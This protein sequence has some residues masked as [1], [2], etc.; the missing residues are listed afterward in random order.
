M[1]YQLKDGRWRAER[2][3]KG[4]RKTRTCATKREALDFEAGVPQKL[5]IE[6]VTQGA[7]VLEWLNAYLDY[8][9]SRFAK[10]VY[11]RKRRAAKIMLQ[12]VSQDTD[13][14]Q[15]KPKHALSIVR[16]AA[17]TWCNGTGNM[18]RSELGAAWAWGIKYEGLPRENPFMMIEKL[19][20][21]RQPRHVP[22]QEDF[23][24]VLRV[25]TP[26]DR[27]FLL[28]CLHT[29][30]RKGELFRLHWSE[31]DF[32]RE[33]VLLGT[34]KRKGGGM[35]YDPIPMTNTLR[36]VLMEKYAERKS[37]DEGLVFTHVDGS[38]YT[39]RQRLTERLCKRAGVQHFS[40]HG[41]RHLTASILAR[42]GVP[43]QQIQRILRHRR[44][45]TTEGYIAQIAPLDN[46]LEQVLGRGAEEEKTLLMLQHQKRP[47]EEVPHGVPHIETTTVKLQ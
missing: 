30:A 6:E 4:K 7:T 43:M 18:L 45:A 9:N 33:Y 24:A 16:Y 46:V 20:V 32:E 10:I 13:C 37:A 42:E 22:S 12:L 38:A 21:D 3:V 19:S 35:E 40:L 44:L 41:I 11:T 17:E 29:A 39:I 14:K 27:L 47:F 36:C 26:R 2:Q 34:R 25:A 5:A 28:A 31:V 1:P 23:Y 15:I 8:A